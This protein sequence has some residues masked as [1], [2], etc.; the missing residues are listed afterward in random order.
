MA[1]RNDELA[2]RLELH[3]AEADEAQQTA[4]LATPGDSVKSASR[5]YGSS[6]CL[7]AGKGT[8]VHI[9]Q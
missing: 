4:R 7:S 9:Y 3:Q 8:K 5:W 2:P 6:E 1:V